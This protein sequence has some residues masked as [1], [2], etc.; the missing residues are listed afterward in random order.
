MYLHLSDAHVSLPLNLEQTGRCVSGVVVFES[1]LD[2]TRDVSNPTL[3]EGA[4]ERTLVL[5]TFPVLHGGSAKHVVQL[6]SLQTNHTH[7]EIE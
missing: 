1:W 5:L 3:E 4:E 6:H 2:P 7:P